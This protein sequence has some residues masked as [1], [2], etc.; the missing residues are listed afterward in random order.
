MTRIF[1]LIVGID[2]YK[3]GYTWNLQSSTHDAK[4]IRNWLTKDLHVPSDHISLL[5]DRKATRENLQAELIRHFLQN[6][7][8]QPGDAMLFYF[9]GHGSSIEAP[10]GWY[11]TDD[12][13]EEDNNVVNVLCTYDHDCRRK[14]GSEGRTVG[15]SDRALLSFMD[16]LAIEKGNNITLILDT[17][18][19]AD[20][21]SSKRLMHLSDTRWTK[22][23]KAGP[24]D[25]LM[26]AESGISTS[27]TRRSR[28]GF[29]QTSSNYSVIAACLPGERAAENKVGGRFTSSLL[30]AVVR[31]HFTRLRKHFV[32]LSCLIETPSVNL[33]IILGDSIERCGRTHGRPSAS[34]V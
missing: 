25:L 12:L 7:A 30:N 14:D 34:I 6:P 13:S 17:C 18:F 29:S 8:I 33:A 27:F 31:F 4:Q 28:P 23:V 19:A 9:A 11:E 32:D 5:L 21:H 22:T 26:E 10:P 2:S 24:S 20:M 16:D 1:A 3:S 15:I